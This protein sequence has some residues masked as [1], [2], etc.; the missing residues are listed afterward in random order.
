M[1]VYVTPQGTT[2]SLGRENAHMKRHK[3][4]QARKRWV[5]TGVLPGE[6]SGGSE[7]R[8]VAFRVDVEMQRWRKWHFLHPFLVPLSSWPSRWSLVAPTPPITMAFTSCVDELHL[9]LAISSPCPKVSS[10]PM[11]WLSPVLLHFLH[12]SYLALYYVFIVCLPWWQV[13]STRA[14]TW[15]TLC[16]WQCWLRE[17]VNIYSH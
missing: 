15:S 11:P 4:L 7:P 14:R 17:T 9:H 10:T 3:E 5:H 12:S 13:N 16:L 6:D 2:G 8:A 1:Y